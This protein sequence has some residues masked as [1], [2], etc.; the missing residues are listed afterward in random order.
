MVRKYK[1]GKTQSETIAGVISDIDTSQLQNAS[2]NEI[3][4]KG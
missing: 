4:V 3:D 2:N 1:D